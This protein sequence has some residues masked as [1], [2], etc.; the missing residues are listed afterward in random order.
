MIMLMIDGFRTSMSLPGVQKDLI[1]TLL[2]AAAAK[3]SPVTLVIMSGGAVCLA[4]YADDPRVGAI[5][6]VGYPGQAGGVGV[7]DVIF[8]EYNPSGRLTQTFY[9]EPF[10][11]EVSFFDM[12]MR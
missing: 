6:F 10:M 2:T 9:K 4:Q 12:G 7:S 11:E 5:I 8:G 3:H 1:E